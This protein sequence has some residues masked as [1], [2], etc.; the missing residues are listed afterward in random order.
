MPNDINITQLELSHSGAGFA[1]V[2]LNILEA[3]FRVKEFAMLVA[4][5]IVLS[6]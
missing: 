5:F 6:Y 1:S 2:I 4:M 3:T